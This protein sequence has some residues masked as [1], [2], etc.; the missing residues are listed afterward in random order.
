MHIQLALRG[1]VQGPIPQISC[2]VDVD[3]AL[4]AVL[5]VEGIS[6][7]SAVPF[8]PCQ[9]VVMCYWGI[10]GPLC[11]TRWIR[12]GT[13]AACPAG[14]TYST[15]DVIMETNKDCLCAM[16]PFCMLT[17]MA[18][19]S[20]SPQSRSQVGLPQVSEGPS[21]QRARF[22]TGRKFLKMSGSSDC[23]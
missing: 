19:S 6:H 4:L 20:C 21:R 7:C 13:P 15:D 10:R 9:A 12:P 8:M 1:S 16:A 2:T 17:G 23:F 3:Q 22:E 18:L 14:Y 5:R 11:Q